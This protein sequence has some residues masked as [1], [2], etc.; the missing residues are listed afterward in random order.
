MNTY[1]HQRSLP[2]TV[3]EVKA[4]RTQATDDRAGQ[5]CMSAAN[6][7]RARMLP[8][9]DHQAGSDPSSIMQFAQ[10][11]STFVVAERAPPQHRVIVA[12][13]SQPD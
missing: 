1:F 6:T 7:E 2:A 13:D 5:A 12:T 3:Q 4:G 10:S 9:F 11:T 8:K